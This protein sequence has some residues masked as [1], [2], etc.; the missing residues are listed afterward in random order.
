[1]RTSARNETMTPKR[2]AVKFFASPDPEAPVDLEAF[3]PLFHR[4][5]QQ[6]SVE[7]LLVD[8]A[9]YAHV[10]NGPGVVLIG[11]DVD[12]GIDSTG[13]RSGLL[14][15]RKR[16]DGSS[17]G[18]LLRD[19]LAKALIAVR[20]IEA[21]G[22]A[23]IAFARDAFEVR[24]VDRLEGPNDDASFAELRAELA[25]VVAAVYPGA[26]VEL[27]QAGDDRREPL[28]IHVSASEAADLDTLISRVASLRGSVDV[29]P[30]VPGPAVPGQTEWDVSVEQLKQLRDANA[31]FVLLDVREQNEVEICELGGQLIPLAQLPARMAELDQLAHIIVHCH[32]GGRS[33]HAVNTL[34][35]AGFGNVWNLQGGIRAWILRIDSSLNDY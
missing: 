7:G 30:G 25:P 26:E 27:T 13:G 3:I 23:K 16:A 10:P 34:R 2:I 8:V 24:V 5:I 6:S 4:F 9:D 14:T 31:D 35:A 20:A 11:H 19:T 28:G 33:S 21:D 1:M 22:S 18:D 29:D 17:L 15:L 32:T 12:Y